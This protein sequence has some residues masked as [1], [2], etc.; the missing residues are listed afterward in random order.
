[1][2]DEIIINP[3]DGLNIEISSGLNKALKPFNT[4]FLN[5]K[6]AGQLSPDEVRAMALQWLEAAEAAEQDAMV[7]A[8]MTQG[9][10]IDLQTAGAFVASLRHRRSKP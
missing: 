7:V 1:M 3:D 8:E 5:E 4:I 9:L 2:A 10:G 6:P